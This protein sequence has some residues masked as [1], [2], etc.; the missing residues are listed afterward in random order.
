M[1]YDSK[2]VKFQTFSLKGKM[3]DW[4]APFDVPFDGNNALL[5]HQLNGRTEDAIKAIF[6]P[7]GEVI[8]IK[9]ILDADT[10]IIAFKTEEQAKLARGS[11]ENEVVCF[12]EVRPPST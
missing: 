7:Y 3:D 2:Y 12:A 6:I 8:Y 1:L 10:C 11:I 5:L 9:V 4:F